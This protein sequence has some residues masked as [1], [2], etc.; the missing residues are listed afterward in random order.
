MMNQLQICEHLDREFKAFCD[1]IPKPLLGSWL[2]ENGYIAGGAIYSLR[3]DQTP[4]D[5]DV[6]IFD[7]RLIKHLKELENFWCC[8]TEYALSRGK[9][10]IVTKFYGS[11]FSNVGEF[12]FKHNMY[13]WCPSYGK[14]LIFTAINDECHLSFENYQYLNSNVL[15]FNE[16]RPHEV[17]R[18]FLRIKKFRKR[19]MKVPIKTYL[20]ILKRSKPVEMVKFK[21]K[22]LR[23]HGGVTY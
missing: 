6:F 19:G 18:C 2:Y 21:C 20:Q 3:H 9:F 15:E 23:S 1:S 7:I 10:Q 8:Q 5:Y 17:E 12:D 11:P 4:N 22:Q 16:N 14:T 13:F